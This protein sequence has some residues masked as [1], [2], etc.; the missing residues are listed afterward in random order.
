MEQR[1]VKV[2]TAVL[3]EI[4]RKVNEQSTVQLAEI[5]RLV[6]H[7]FHV[8]SNAQLAEVLYTE[9]KLPVLKRGKTGPS[10]DQDVL[11]KLAETHPLPRAIIEYRTLTKLKS[12]YL[13]TLPLLLGKDGRIHTTFNQAATATGRLSSTDPNL[14]NI[15]IRTEL[16]REIRRAFVAEPGNVLISADYSQIELRLLAHVS[17]DPGLIEA[18][19]RDEDVHTRTAADVF[20]VQP[21]QVTREQRSAAKMVNFGIA[22]GL[23]PH[24]LST[25]LNIPNEEAASIIERYFQRYGGIKRYLDETIEKA[26]RTG[27][28]ETLF[29]RRRFMSDIHSRNRNAAMAAERAAINMPI[30]GTAADLIKMAM[31]ELE[32]CLAREGSGAQMLLQVHDELLLEAPE[33]EAE[34]IKALARRC[35]SNVTVLKVPLRVDVGVGPNWA[36]SH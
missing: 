21:D 23:S 28:V 30:Q 34:A 3:G 33:A 4:E 29:G 12:T 36:L 11:E 18:F 8:G 35:M 16:G 26:R 14:Q 5:Y 2:D 31:I 1:G 10:T 9:L 24:G 22:Y 15:P 6:G 19:T 20:G 17:E 13:D 32:K 7:E 27:Y 25:R